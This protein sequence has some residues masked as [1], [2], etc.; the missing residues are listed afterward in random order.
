MPDMKTLHRSLLTTVLA[1]ACLLASPAASLAQAI[2]TSGHGDI[3]AAY[4]AVAKEF[5]PHWHV[6]SGAVVDGSPLGADTEFETA[7][8]IART[9]ATRT[10]PTGLS[11]TLGVADGTLIYAL[12]SSAYQPNL[13]FGVEELVP[14]DWD[15]VITLT[16]TSWSAPSGANFALYTTNL[17]GTSVVDRVFSTFAPGA[18]DLSNSFTMTPGDH[19]HFQWAFTEQGSYAFDFTWTGT[20]VGDGAIATTGT[21]N[22]EVVPEPST[23]GLLALGALGLAWVLRRRRTA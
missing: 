6:H 5:E 4:D 3:G 10:S 11:S 12:G 20:H 13:G 18:T 23:Y 16:L 22:V 7:D 19:V 17:A 21:F 9:Q 1:S 14:D 2:Y 8:L 15:G